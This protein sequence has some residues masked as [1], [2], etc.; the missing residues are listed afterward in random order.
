M[1]LLML[2][3]FLS[4]FV[5]IY[6]DFPEIENKD[7]YGLR[8]NLDNQDLPS[9]DSVKVKSKEINVFKASEN[10][11]VRYGK[12]EEAKIF[13]AN[14]EELK[15]LSEA[16]A[17]E[18]VKLL[19]NLK[20]IESTSEKLF[21]HDLWLDKKISDKYFPVHKIY[22]QDE[23][24]TQI[25]ISSVNGEVLQH[26]TFSERILAWFGAIPHLI[27]FKDFAGYGFLWK[28][29]LMIISLLG[30]F[31]CISGLITGFIR[32]KN[33]KKTKFKFTPYASKL[34]SIHH[35]L[36]FIFGVFALSW[37]FSGFMSLNP[38]S[39]FENQEEERK[40]ENLWLER[41]SEVK[42]FPELAE[43]LKEANVKNIKIKKFDNE[44]II[45]FNT[46]KFKGIRFYSGDL[47]NS[48]DLRLIND[49]KQ[50]IKKVYNL[51]AENLELLKEF[52]NYYY[53]TTKEKVLPVVKA[54]FED[55]LKT[56][57]YFDP[58]TLDIVKV[59]NK[60]SRL[61]RWLY[62]ALHRFD[63][64]Y[65]YKILWYSVMFILLTGGTFLAVTGNLFLFRKKMK[66]RKNKI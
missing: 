28:I 12:N 27:Y 50:K 52:D 33:R 66:Q 5:L 42:T 53:K 48:D 54:E 21:Q 31:M 32:F 56:V 35:Y 13:A 47:I 22:F 39:V 60:V 9:L 37:V 1:A 65:D 61:N 36:G 2:I 40:L 38:L 43:R 46:E 26:T 15:N 14:K 4:G 51:P 41:F 25:Y 59:T 64:I 49:L 17:I 58:L 55:E 44:E 6:S 29:I 63:F 16:K 23:D 3:W 11:F 45:V 30:T 34:Y 8:E 19:F 10:V 7:F 57:L 20:N 24:E 62:K 18:K